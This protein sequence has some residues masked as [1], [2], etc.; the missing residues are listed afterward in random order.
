[1]EYFIIKVG[2]YQEVAT[3]RNAADNFFGPL[4]S[5]YP[6]DHK[7]LDILYESSVR[8]YDRHTHNTII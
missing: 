6:E 4:S 7:S 1:M 8:L 3:I 5:L 2:V